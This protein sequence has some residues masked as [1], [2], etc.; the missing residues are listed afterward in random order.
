MKDKTNCKAVYIIT[1]GYHESIFDAALLEHYFQ[2]KTYFTVVDNITKADLIIL[3]GCCVKQSNEDQSRE[4]IK[5]IHE[6]KRD[7]A[8]LIVSG[9]LTK[10]RPELLEHEKKFSELRQEIY[11][12]IGLKRKSHTHFPGFSFWNNHKNL[13]NITKAHMRQRTVS[14]YASY[15]KGYF[16]SILQ[17]CPG[18]IERILSLYSDYM[19]S[20][21]DVWDH[22]AYTIKICTGCC[23]NCSYCSIKQS[24][25]EI[26][27]I[28]IEK[29][30]MDFIAGLEQ[31]YTDFAFIGTDIGDYGKDLGTDLQYLLETIV[32]LPG[33]FRLR[34]RNVN[35]R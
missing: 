13:I 5:I 3:L 23:G 27:S 19:E 11:N 31:N 22:R 6:Q 29:V 15:C 14:E 12:V 2:K 7:D 16:R 30:Q 21:I 18:V 32:K 4:L 20:R 35:P 25:G 1:N 24:R 9:C 17:S 10:V 28:P 26:Q 33:H 8:K 34:L